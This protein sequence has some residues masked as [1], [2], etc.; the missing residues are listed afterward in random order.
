MTKRLNNGITYSM[1]AW[2]P[3]RKE[4]YRL[5]RIKHNKRLKPYN[6]ALYQKHKVKIRKNAMD[7]YYYEK[8][9]RA[10]SIMFRLADENRFKHKI[11]ALQKVSNKK[12]PHCV[13]CKTKDIRV[14]SINHIK[15]G[16]QKDNK[17]YGNMS[18][19][20]KRGFLLKSV[21]VKNMEGNRAKRNQEK[22]WR[23]RALKGGF[24][25]FKHEYVF[26]LQKTNKSRIIDE[27]KDF[28]R[29]NH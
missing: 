20:I 9:N 4:Y 2:T 15:G 12:I 21:I 26:I 11:L 10:N 27:L 18:E 3:K 28:N 16:G 7:K 1:Q 13:K 19:A 8:K 22:L 23:L 14:L 5:W 24:Y 29:F 17:K 6:R 25:I